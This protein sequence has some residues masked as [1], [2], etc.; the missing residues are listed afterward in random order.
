[1][2]ASMVRLQVGDVVT[3]GAKILTE[4]IFG[5]RTLPALMTFLNLEIAEVH[6]SWL[7]MHMEQ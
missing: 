1:M 2:F 6:G 5:L 4:I 7:T 3:S